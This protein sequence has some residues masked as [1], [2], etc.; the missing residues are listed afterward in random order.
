MQTTNDTELINRLAAALAQQLRPAIPLEV[1]LWDIK[2]IATLLKRS[3]AHV[4]E[5]MA[6]LPDFPKAVRLPTGRAARSQALYWAREV[7]AWTAKYQD[8]H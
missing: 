7:L 1:D 8:K 5:H 6:C 2:T 4:R 3:E